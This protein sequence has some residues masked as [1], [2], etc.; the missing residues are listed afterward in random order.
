MDVA[1]DQN[2]LSG[3]AEM[4][5]ECMEENDGI[6]LAA[7]QVGLTCRAFVMKCHATSGIIA[8]FNPRILWASTKMVE[9]AEGCLSYPGRFLKITR[10]KQIKASWTDS[11]GKTQIRAFNK[12]DARVFQHELDHL[13]GIT[14]DMRYYE[15][16]NHASRWFE[17]ET[18]RLACL[19]TV[20]R[21]DEP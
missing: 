1:S 2:D 20:G 18:E 5:I 6:G 19:E 21:K 4:L 13:N 16:M 11:H 15:G 8:A 14:F 3:L 12:L 10:P 9:M 7:N 17:T